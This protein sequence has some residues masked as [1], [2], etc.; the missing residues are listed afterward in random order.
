MK[1]KQLKELLIA[2]SNKKHEDFSTKLK[3]NDKYKILGIKLG[4]L[5]TLAK[6]I[7]KKEGLSHIDDFLNYKESL[8]YEEV[9][10]SYFTL[11]YLVKKLDVL[12]VYKYIDKLLEY[13]NSWA[14]NDA[15]ALAIVPKKIDLPSYFEYL[16][17]K[18]DSHYFW[19]IRFG[20]V[21]LMKTYL[22]DDY[23][24]QTLEKLYNVHNNEYYVQMA[25]GWAYATA[26]A[27]Q[28]DKTYP[29]IFEKRIDN[30]VN[31]IAIQKSIESSRIKEE[32]KIKLREL[33]IEINK[34]L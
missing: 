18:L 4:E 17:S 8:F 29:Y 7:S 3:I 16:V 27:K 11:S 25:L 5:K 24:E 14:T 9:L 28:R 2:K 20:I 30:K 12:V 13:N 26:L 33:R 15:I 23:I 6:E 19:D 21:S 32:D 31:K 1:Q 22:T 34:L 10:I